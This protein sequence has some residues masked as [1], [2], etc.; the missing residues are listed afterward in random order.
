MHLYRTQ[1]AFL[2]AVLSLSQLTAASDIILNQYQ[3]CIRFFGSVSAEIELPDA[4]P[5]RN[6]N[7]SITCP[8]QMRL[9]AV[10]GATLDI[11]PPTS[12]LSSPDNPSTLSAELRLQAIAGQLDPPLDHLRLQPQLITNGSISGPFQNNGAPA[13]IA[14]DEARTA[15]DISPTWTI[16][17]TQASLIELPDVD[18][19]SQG[20]YVGCFYKGSNYY[21]GTSSDLDAPDGGCWRDQ[22]FLFN[23]RASA[24]NFTFRFSNN[25]A[26]VEVWTSTEYFLP[27]RDSGTV[28]GV[29]TGTNTSVYMIFGGNRNVPSV[30]DYDFWEMAEMDYEVEIANAEMRKGMVLVK[31]IDGLPVLMNDTGRGGDGE[32]YAAGNGSYSEQ[33]SGVA[34]VLVGRGGGVLTLGLCLC[35]ELLGSWPCC[36][37]ELFLRTTA[38][39]TTQM[40]AAASARHRTK[41][42]SRSHACI[43]LS[44]LKEFCYGFH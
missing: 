5:T 36:K 17:G 25:E 41:L 16:N 15:R 2:L 23:Q 40:K 21:C 29:G 13:L 20:V 11:C 30:V 38:L 24:M 42:L 35:W 28:D 37:T 8:T 12:S 6:Y 1:H 34:A 26:S 27:R 44:D 39:G 10:S 22:Q 3:Y 33:E 9:P 7:D 43:R 18:D 4:I 31:G 19:R 14:F 32:S